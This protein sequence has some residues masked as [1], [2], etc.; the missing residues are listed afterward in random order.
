MNPSEL[1]QMLSGTRNFQDTYIVLRC[2]RRAS[3]AVGFFSLPLSLFTKP[4]LEVFAHETII[5]L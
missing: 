4:E 1:L 3:F 5:S 2:F